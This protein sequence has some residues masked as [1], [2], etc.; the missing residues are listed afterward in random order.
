[1]AFAFQDTEKSL[2]DY[3]AG[4]FCFSEY[5]RHADAWAWL[6]DKPYYGEACIPQTYVVKVWTEYFDF[7]EFIDDRS[8]CPQNVIVVKKR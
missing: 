5:D 8:L 4:Q 1:L 2:A 6:N 3:E 7:L